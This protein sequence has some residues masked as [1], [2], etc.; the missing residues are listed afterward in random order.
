MIQ[1]IVLH[2]RLFF[3]RSRFADLLKSLEQRL[4][5]SLTRV[6]GYRNG[7][8]LEV[9]H[10]VFHTL[11]PRDILHDLIA[12]CLAMQFAL[13]YHGLFIGLFGGFGRCLCRLIRICRIAERQR[14]KGEK[15]QD[16]F[17]DY[18]DLGA[19]LLKNLHICKKFCNFVAEK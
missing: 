2:F 14:T 8:V 11:L 16:F 13:Q 5:I 1:L 3:N 7:L 18:F 6:V 10:Q 4:Q 9:A 12:T 19:K 15:K 17:H